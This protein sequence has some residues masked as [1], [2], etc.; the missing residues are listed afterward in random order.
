MSH[1]IPQPDMESSPGRVGAMEVMSRLATVI[2]NAKLDCE[3]RARLDQSLV[4]FMALERRR[5]VR[6]NL[7]DARTQRDR[8]EAFLL[9]LKELD[10]LESSEPDHSVY[11]EV[12]FLFDDIANAAR[13]GA[14][15]M[16][17]LSPPFL[18]A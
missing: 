6:R 5:M 17:Q 13:Q 11:K 14:D 8:I 2:R 4:R 16:R 9:L 7:L 12:A 1:T 15:L 10:E 18:S 3:C